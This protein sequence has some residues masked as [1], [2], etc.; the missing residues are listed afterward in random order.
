M[1]PKF[2][3][4]NG[5]Y[6]IWNSESLKELRLTDEEKTQID[7]YGVEAYGFFCY[8]A[9]KV[10]DKYNDDIAKLRRGLRVIKG[11]LQLA[12]NSMPQGELCIIPLTSNIGY[13]N[14]SHIIVHFRGAEPDLGRKGFQP[15]LQNLAE[16]IAAGLVG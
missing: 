8:S 12:T 2:K 16:R 3:R 5:V 6:D 4:L 13:Q 10:L 1:P 7:Q 14:Q 11:G 15:E 9:P